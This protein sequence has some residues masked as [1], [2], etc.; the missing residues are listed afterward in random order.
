MYFAF[1]FHSI[2]RTFQDNIADVAVNQKD[3][4]MRC[5]EASHTSISRQVVRM[6]V[7][8]VHE[9]RNAHHV[10]TVC[11]LHCF[12]GGGWDNNFMIHDQ[13][14]VEIMKVDTT[15][16]VGLRGLAAIHIMV[17]SYID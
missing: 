14:S 4:G 1:P 10:P 7:D 17:T 12:G 8:M 9:I 2:K 11:I 13:D 5:I 15:A 16:T 3:R 6:L